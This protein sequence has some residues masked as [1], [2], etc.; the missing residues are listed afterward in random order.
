[1]SE[2]RPLWE[3]YS[4]K[5]IMLG[6]KE[7]GCSDLSAVIIQTYCDLSTEFCPAN[8]E[9]VAEKLDLPKNRST[10]TKITGTLGLAAQAY[11]DLCS[12]PEPYIV[13]KP[14]EQV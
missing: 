5:A 6:A 4:P 9:Q 2:K 12:Q 11:R 1:M 14:D 10:Q 7:F 8:W 3:C 13:Q